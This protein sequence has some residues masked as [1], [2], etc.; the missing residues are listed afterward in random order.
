[1]EA[2]V[3]SLAQILIAAAKAVRAASPRG[4]AGSRWLRRSSGFAAK[5]V[6]ERRGEEVG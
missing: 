4:V 2:G 3:R 5:G 6:V 1:M